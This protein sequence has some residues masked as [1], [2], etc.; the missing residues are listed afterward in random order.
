[1]SVIEPRFAAWSYLLYSGAFVL[2]ISAAALLAY[3]S[4]RHSAGVYTLLSFLVL[5]GFAAT[6]FALGR[7]GDHPVAAGLFADAVVVLFGAFVLALWSWFG[8]LSTSSLSFGGFDVARLAFFAL[9]LVAALA[10]LRRFR[11]PLLML[12]VVVLAWLFVVDLV[13]GGGDWSAVVTFAVGLG[14]LVVAV[15]VDAGSSRPYGFWLHVGAGATI[16]GSLLWFLHHGHFEWVLI[17]LAGLIYVKLA[18][19]LGRSSWAVLGSLGILASAAHFAASF[20]HTQ[21]SPAIATQPSS[22]SRGWVP[23][24]VFG[25]AGTLLV[26]LGGLLARRAGSAQR[27]L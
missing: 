17:A 18:D 1:M 4:G 24:V 9:T 5:L 6:A 20:S 11:F 8:W 13:S 22:D 27:R 7:S 15:P 21:I 26:L 14:F 12:T 19:L 25:L 3:L 10:A 2:L 23:A 16:G